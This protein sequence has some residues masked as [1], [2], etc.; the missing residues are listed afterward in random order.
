MA[1]PEDF[2]SPERHRCVGSLKSGAARRWTNVR[3]ERV[4]KAEGG[5]AHHVKP[6]RTRTG[7]RLVRRAP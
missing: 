4:K 3:K 2:V 7:D 6:G 5:S 1:R